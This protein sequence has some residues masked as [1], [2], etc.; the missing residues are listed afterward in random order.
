MAPDRDRPRV[1][2]RD[3]RGA[4]PFRVGAIFLAVTAVLVFLGFN[5]G[6]P[7]GHERLAL[8]PATVLEVYGG[9]IGPADLTAAGYRYDTA[10]GDGG[11]WAPDGSVEHAGP[12]DF[13]VPVRAVDPFGNTR[14]GLDGS[15]KVNRKDWGVNWNA[16]LEAGGVLVSEK[17]T[18]EFE[19]SAIKAGDPS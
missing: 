12:A 15:V 9:R 2:R 19:V 4:D 5:K 13:F 8:T 1:A 6:L 3:R 10:G 14:L 11:W 16:A 18:L 7:F 17:V